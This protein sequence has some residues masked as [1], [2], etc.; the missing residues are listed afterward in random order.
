MAC[1]FLN[2]TSFSGI[3]ASTAGPIGGYTQKS[4]YKLDCRFPVSTIT[5]RIRQAAALKEKII[6]VEASSWQST[7]AKVD[8]LKYKD[9]E[10]LYYMDPPF[11]SKAKRLYTFSFEEN[12]HTELHDFLVEIR[13]PWILSYDPAMPIIEMYSENGCD[14]KRINILYSISSTNPQ[15]KAQEVV[16]TNLPQLPEETRLWRSR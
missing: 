3:L 13:Q 14:P 10:V 5:K 12:D 16:I 4:Q 9:N 7:M 1:I 11:Y 2:R 8:N 6:S 15:V